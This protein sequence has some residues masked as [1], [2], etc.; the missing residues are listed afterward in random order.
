M[1]KPKPKHIRTWGV[2]ACTIIVAVCSFIGNGSVWPALAETFGLVF[3]WA[4][5]YEEEGE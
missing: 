5:F 1:R 2:L 4:L 3:F